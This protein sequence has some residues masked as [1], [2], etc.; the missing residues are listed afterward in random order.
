MICE[1]KGLPIC[2]QCFDDHIGISHKKVEIEDIQ[3]TFHIELA[4]KNKD[5]D[6]FFTK[7]EETGMGKYVD[8]FEVAKDSVM[9][10]KNY[11]DTQPPWD[12]S[13]AAYDNWL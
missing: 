3:E 10:V 9:L 4:K 7:Y 8:F 12:K 6:A 13:A 11:Y 2:K 5:A 1:C